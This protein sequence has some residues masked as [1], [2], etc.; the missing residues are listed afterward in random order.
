MSQPPSNRRRTRRQAPKK[1]VKLQ[2]RKGSWGFGPN[3]AR[4]LLDLSLDGARLIVAAEL[5]V[6]QEVSLNLEGPWQKEPLTRAARVRWCQALAD[7]SFCVGVLFDK[8]LPYADV[9][10]LAAFNG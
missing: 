4:T 2:C 10:D 7:G 6:G 3:V 1:T 8:T 9:L 5:A